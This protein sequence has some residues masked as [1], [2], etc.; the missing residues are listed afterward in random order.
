MAIFILRNYRGLFPLRVFRQLDQKHCGSY[1]R[2]MILR[3]VLLL[4]IITGRMDAYAQNTPA[5][6]TDSLG[7]VHLT[8]VFNGSV[9]DFLATN[10][11]YPNAAKEAGL[12]GRVIIKFI[13][14]TAGQ[15][16]EIF[17]FKSSGYV[18]LD[19]EAMRVIATMPP[20]KPGTIDGV[21]VSMPF[22]LPITYE[23]DNGFS[24][25][26]GNSLAIKNYPIP[27]MDSSGHLGLYAYDSN[28]IGYANRII[29]STFFTLQ[30]LWLYV[31]LNYP[32]DSWQEREEG[33]A[34]VGFEIGADGMVAGAQILESSG[35]PLLDEE[36]LRL[37]KGTPKWP[38]ASSGGQAVPVDLVIPMR[39]ARR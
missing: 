30:S 28:G 8:P 21:P 16:N 12:Q 6:I 15:I 31:H 34:M 9:T 38:I 39:F 20:W 37:I 2:A 32:K 18:M 25:T 5:S 22:T 10:I 29:T 27:N 33:K 3:W 1:I 4:L 13:V 35:H 14:D 7:K 23:V 26:Y 36:A 17:V 24:P 19:A 11:R